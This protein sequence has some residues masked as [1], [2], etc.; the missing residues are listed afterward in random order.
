MLVLLALALA[1]EPKSRAG[2]PSAAEADRVVQQVLGSWK[3]SD[4]IAPAARMGPAESA[5]GGMR[6]AEQLKR[7]GLSIQKQRFQSGDVS[8]GKPSFGV[9]S[10]TG[11]FPHSELESLTP[12]ES[13]ADALKRSRAIAK[14]LEVEQWSPGWTKGR[15]VVLIYC[16]DSDG[17]KFAQ[18]IVPGSS[19]RAVA[20][21]ASR[22]VLCLTRDGQP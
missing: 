7:A 5:I 16:P 20:I 14:W 6:T 3:V 22:E 4:V 9:T 10:W 1:D 17:H 12:G 15:S 19:G 13:E 11:E 2:A 8:C 18:L 21:T